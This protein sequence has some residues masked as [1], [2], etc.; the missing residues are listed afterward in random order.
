MPTLFVTLD[1]PSNLLKECTQVHSFA[2][3]IAG[4]FWGNLDLFLGGHSASLRV[5]SRNPVRAV[6]LTQNIALH[7]KSGRNA[8]KCIPLPAILRSKI[9][10]T[11]I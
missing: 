3:K 9:G 7:F 4:Q 2:R 8:L 5:P 11:W 6:L 10:A 1:A